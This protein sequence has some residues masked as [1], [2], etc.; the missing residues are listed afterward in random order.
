MY[1]SPFNIETL[2]SLEP[3]NENVTAL[4]LLQTAIDQGLI[5]A[6]FPTNLWVLQSFRYKENW[7]WY[8]GDH[9]EE[10]Y[11]TDK[12]GRPV[13]RYP[14]K[15]NPIRNFARKHA[16]LVLGDISDGQSVPVRSMVKPKL[17]WWGEEP[18]ESVKK[19]AKKTQ[20][21]LQEVWSNSNPRSM[22]YE[23]ALVS[24]ILGGHIFRVNYVPYRKDVSIPITVR[25]ILPDYFLPLWS[26][27]NPWDLLEAYMVYRV[28]RATAE[29]QWPSMKMDG[30]NLAFITYVEHW[31]KENYSVLI[32]GKPLETRYENKNGL[33]IRVKYENEPNPFGF[34]PMVYVPRLREGSNYGSP[35][36]PDIK[37]LQ[38]EFNSR[39]ADVGDAVRK[40][41]HRRR[42]GR[43]ISREPE[44]RDLDKNSGTGEK[45]LDIGYTN[46]AYEDKPELWAEDPPDWHGEVIAY[47]EFLWDQLNR[48]GSLGPTAF[49]EDEG[50]QR[51][52]LTLAFRMWPATII[53]KTQ[54]MFWTDGLNA[55]DRMILRIANEH[56]VEINGFRIPDDFIMQYD[57]QKD[58]DP[59]IPRDRE[60]EVSEIVA[61]VSGENPT[62]SIET[63]LEKFGDIPDVKE[64][65][66]KIQE[67]L[68]KKQEN[69]M[70]LK[71][72][73]HEQ[74]AYK[75]A[76]PSGG[77]EGGE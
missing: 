64:E 42:L 74:D 18:P 58:W 52:A 34:V 6:G 19:Q 25:G 46:P 63:A 54:R 22:F 48:E 35:L 59:M 11:G 75:P 32:D 20:F 16:S 27:D 23:N 47:N 60:A 1:L 33:N 53:G 37:G 66:A 21:F 40:A 38:I 68:D 24:Q 45:Y 7:A 61:R 72:Q 2:P 36:V 31:T 62:L 30:P 73:G 65:I 26:A 28:P 44:S 4:G 49:G 3:G 56:K 55:V 51:S 50:S 77:L 29:R 12:D 43:N 8:R 5:P 39:M 69:A 67:M 13:Y 14:L 70:S 9:L 57:I 41:I 71:G 15:M 10:I 76:K 17:A